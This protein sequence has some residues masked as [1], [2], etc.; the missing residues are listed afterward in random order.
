MIA[1]VLLFAFFLG[2]VVYQALFFAKRKARHSQSWEVILSQISPI[3]PGLLS[4][5]TQLNGKRDTQPGAI[6]ASG[7]WHTVGGMQGIRKLKTN[8]EAMLELAIYAERW[9]SYHGPVFSE[10]VRRDALALRRAIRV[11]RLRYF[12]ARSEEN[13]SDPLIKAFIAYDHARTRLLAIYETTHVG[14]LPQLEAV[15]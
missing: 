11:L 1:A 12:F 3:E 6:S 14:L 2:A 15:L 10:L 8:A 9:N 5:V 4:I 7:I 13:I